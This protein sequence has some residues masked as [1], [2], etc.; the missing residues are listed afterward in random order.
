MALYCD[1]EDNIWIGTYN[2]GL[3]IYNQKTK[4]FRHYRF[5]PDDTTTISSDHPWGFVRDRWGNMWVATVNYGLNL[6]KPGESKFY[7]IWKLLILHF[8][9][10]QLMSEALT[11]MFIDSKDRLWI[12]SGMGLWKWL[13][14]NVDFS[15]PKPIGF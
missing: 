3:N 14:C 13:N 5:N 4:K 7:Q 12:G 2:G 10:H 15:K 8:W 1:P 9:F 11:H 6:M